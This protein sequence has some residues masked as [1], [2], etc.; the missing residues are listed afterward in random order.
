[1]TGTSSDTIYLLGS[2]LNGIESVVIENKQTMQLASFANLEAAKA[3][4][5]QAYD[6]L[7][8]P[9]F[10]P[11]YPPGKEEMA[12]HQGFMRLAAF[13][14]VIFGLNKKD[15]LEVFSHWREKDASLFQTRDRFFGDLDFW[16][17]PMRSGFL[18][19]YGVLDIVWDIESTPFIG[20]DG[21]M[22]IRIN[23]YSFQ[24]APTVH[25]NH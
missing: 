6:L 4:F 14:P 3:N 5:V 7:L 19:T 25:L 9:S 13:Y 22:V 11:S 20:P 10:T 24:M 23:E 15:Y 16:H 17:C 18:K 21:K 1:M 2:R 8:A 12:Y